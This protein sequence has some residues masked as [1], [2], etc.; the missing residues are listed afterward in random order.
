[1]KL[2]K[3]SSLVLVVLILMSMTVT[4]F[5]ADSTI[6][7]TGKD[8]FEF[9][10][11]SEYTTSDLF[12][13]FKGVMPGDERSETITIKNTSK[14]CDY[15]IVSMRAELHNELP[16]S[17]KDAN[18][19]HQTVKDEAGSLAQMHKFLANMHLVVKN[20]STVIFEGTADQLDG[21]E[22]AVK[23]GTLRRN[24]SMTLTADL[25]VDM[26]MGNE[27]QNFAGEVDWVFSV[28]E[29]NDPD[30]PKTGDETRILPYIL[31]LTVGVTGM[32]VL[33]IG[34]RKRQN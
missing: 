34:K 2:R 27:F 1:M 12:D 9:A 6:T 21:L 8:K 10:P 25:T 4:A 18:P 29:R 13:G 16:E 14:S 15:I 7:Y 22:K 30:K 20:G 31:L 33:L 23:L 28:E 5:A 11:G 26:D 32:A 3:I 24:K 19:M 17:N